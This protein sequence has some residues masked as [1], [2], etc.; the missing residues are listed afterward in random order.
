MGRTVLH[1]GGSTAWSQN[2]AARVNT[3]IEDSGL[4]VREVADQSGIARET[5]RRR[6]ANLTPFTVD[7][8][9]AIA[10]VLDADS[11]TFLNSD[12]WSQAS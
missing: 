11:D 12:Y 9:E 6:L 2:I 8:L 5:L 10:E 1:M 3:T 4:S 7:E